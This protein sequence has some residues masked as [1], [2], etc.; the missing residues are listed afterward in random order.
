[1]AGDGDLGGP[2]SSHNCWAPEPKPGPLTETF[3]AGQ[4]GHHLSGFSLWCIP[5]ISETSPPITAG[6]G[7]AWPR[8]EVLQ[9]S[10]G[11]YSIH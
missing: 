1:V 10:R 2:Q 5:L 6:S 11:G 3:I 7:A 4:A 8:H 9:R